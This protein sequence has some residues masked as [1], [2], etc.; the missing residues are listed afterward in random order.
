MFGYPNFTLWILIGALDIIGHSPWGFSG[1]ILEIFL[2]GEIRR[3]LILGAPGR[4]ISPFLISPDQ[5]MER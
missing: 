2:L 5:D 1:P 3:Q 4:R